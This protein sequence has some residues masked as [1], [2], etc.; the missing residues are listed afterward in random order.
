MSDIHSHI[1]TISDKAVKNIALDFIS[2]L[3]DNDMK[4]ERAGGYWKNQSYWYVKYNDEYVCFILIN[5]IGDEERFAPLTVWT[6]DSN[7]HWYGD[8]NLQDSIK[9][10]AVRHID[11]CEKC[12]ACSGGTVKNIFG[13]Q[14]DNVCRTAFRFINPDSYELK[15][16]KKL[17]LLRKS[18]IIKGNTYDK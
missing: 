17:I 3:I 9:N 6:D 2:F 13:K 14:Y 15:C 7:S 1:S 11:I 10:I 8:C 5:G 16:L 12:G 18:D 4:F